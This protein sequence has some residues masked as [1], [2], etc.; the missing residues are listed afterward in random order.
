M[1]W[2][3]ATFCRLNLIED[4]E[5]RHGFGGGAGLETAPRKYWVEHR[6]KVKLTHGMRPGLC[7][8]FV[9][10]NPV[11]AQHSV[12]LGKWIGSDSQILYTNLNGFR[13]V[14]GVKLGGIRLCKV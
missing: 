1:L 6:R 14:E 10:G 9:G 12:E 2:S 3:S 4:D 8:A 7:G 5:A 11:M 13:V